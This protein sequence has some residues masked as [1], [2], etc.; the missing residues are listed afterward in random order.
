MINN[1]EYSATN[2]TIGLMYKDL[3]LTAQLVK[4]KSGNIIV[5]S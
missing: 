2:M 5:Y 4:G 3:K 1:K